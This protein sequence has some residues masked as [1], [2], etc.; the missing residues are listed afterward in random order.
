[1][2]NQTDPQLELFS[3]QAAPGGLK[4]QPPRKSFFLRIRSYEKAVLIIIAFIT[5][6]IVSFSLGVEKG[7]RI[8]SANSLIERAALIK[9]AQP[10][11]YEPVQKQDAALDN[12]SAQVVGTESVAKAKTA[13]DQK[14][15]KGYTI[16]LA[17]Y[18]M[19]A[20]AQQEADMLKKKG[21]SP[22]FLNKGNYVV[23][24]V[25]NFPDRSTAESLLSELKKQKRYSGC[26][27]RRL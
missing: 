24:C 6:S 15:A 5:I 9:P 21:L 12:T 18:K 11:V 2:E 23:L 22:L 17:S 20:N 1:M 16:Q 27:I 10:K 4:G 26:L 3:Q 13:I 14:T 25:G 19:K 8:V 7:K